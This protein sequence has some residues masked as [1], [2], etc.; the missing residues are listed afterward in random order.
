MN[1]KKLKKIMTDLAAGHISQKEAD[2]LI[3]SE[4]V[5]QSKPVGKSEGKILHKKNKLK[6]ESGRKI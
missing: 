1:N 4:K 2:Q 5:V 3:K 6:S